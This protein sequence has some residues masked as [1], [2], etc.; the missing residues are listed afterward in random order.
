MKFFLNKFKN[1]FVLEPYILK[2][3]NSYFIM[4]DKNKI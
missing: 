2:M 4:I 3:Y 1:I